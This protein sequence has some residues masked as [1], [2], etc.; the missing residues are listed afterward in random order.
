[1]VRGKQASKLLGLLEKARRVH[2]TQR[3]PLGWVLSHRSAAAWKTKQKIAEV[4]R[5]RLWG[6]VW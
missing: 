6:G 4:E 2:S 3:C 1:M 5:D